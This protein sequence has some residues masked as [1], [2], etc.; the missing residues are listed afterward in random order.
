MLLAALHTWAID[1]AD[2][3]SPEAR[4]AA[5][6][7]ANS[8]A[9][10]IEASDVEAYRALLDATA[11]LVSGLGNQLFTA[12]EVAVRGR[13]KFHAAATDANIDWA[14]ATATAEALANL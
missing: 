8:V 5:A 11:A 4:K 13:V 2:Q 9:R 14:A 1:H 7:A 12:T 3:S 6:S 10:R